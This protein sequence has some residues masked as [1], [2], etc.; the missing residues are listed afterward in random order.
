M[1]QAAR[2]GARGHGG[3][4]VRRKESQ[5]NYSS[6]L[7]S[8]REKER[9]PSMFTQLKQWD[10]RKWEGIPWISF[11]ASSLPWS[12]TAPSPAVITASSILVCQG[13]FQKYFRHIHICTSTKPNNVL[14]FVFNTTKY[15]GNYFYQCISIFLF[16]VNYLNVI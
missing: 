12:C 8:Q 15:F 4:R 6:G 3:V 5:C 13:S 1:Q 16:L 10:N 11:L 9:K 2:R 7:K 14:K